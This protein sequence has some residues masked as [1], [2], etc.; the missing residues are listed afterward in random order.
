M[1]A[2]LNRING[3]KFPEDM[4]GTDI[5]ELGRFRL[6]GVAELSPLHRDG[7]IRIAC[8]KVRGA[9][10]GGRALQRTARVAATENDRHLTAPA[11]RRIFSYYPGVPH[12]RG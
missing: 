1:S 11:T 7:A 4:A 6:A 10:S 3:L 12:Q 2:F 9:K 5:Q 8:D